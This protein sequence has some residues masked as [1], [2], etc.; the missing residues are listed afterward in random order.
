LILCVFNKGV[1]YVIVVFFTLFSL[2]SSFNVYAAVNTNLKQ[3][4]LDGINE[5]R[6]SR[7][8][9]LRNAASIVTVKKLNVGGVFSSAVYEVELAPKLGQ[10][11][12][13]KKF[14]IC[15]QF[16]DENQFAYEVERFAILRNA[17]DQAKEIGITPPIS[18][19]VHFV[20]YRGHAEYTDENNRIQKLVLLERAEG[21]S[22]AQLLEDYVLQKDNSLNTAFFWNEIGAR[23]AKFH[24]TLGEVKG[25]TYTSY[26]HGDLHAWNIFVDR[27][28]LL[29]NGVLNFIDY[30]TLIDS[31]LSVKQDISTDLKIMF[32]RTYKI[33]TGQYMEIIRDQIYK[34]V[35]SFE[36]AYQYL[37][38]VAERIQWTFSE[39][40]QGYIN[41][42]LFS[43]L[44]L[45]IDDEGQAI[46]SSHPVIKRNLKLAPISQIATKDSFFRANP[47][48]RPQE[49]PKPAPKPAPKSVPKP[50]LKPAAKLAP[51]HHAVKM[52]PKRPAAKPVPRRVAAKPVPKPAVKAPPKRPA[53]KL[54]PRHPAVKMPPKRPAAK[55]ALRRPAAKA[56]PRRPVARA[57]PRSKRKVPFVKKGRR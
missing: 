20:K 12:M 11:A 32:G 37:K 21:T 51:R 31:M 9:G 18:R 46:L 5:D 34:I 7:H 36:E 24:L 53:A 14:I 6:V 19:F 35:G 29:R 55:A 3:A 57:V 48:L 43:G 10:E 17:F 4:I 39:I 56:A 40:M 8:K 33:F 22:L 50:R 41:E 26:P 27:K 38:V 44:N 16:K 47:R 25:N 45:S 42:F 30:A 52:P 23:L 2:F 54:A 1:N 15:K 49:A 28:T 13:K